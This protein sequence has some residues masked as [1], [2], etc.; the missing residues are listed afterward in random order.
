M[1]ECPLT[2]AQLV[3]L[4]AAEE[5]N[6][7][8]AA[9]RAYISQQCASNHIKNLEAQYGIALFNRKPSLTLT[10]A[11]EYLQQSLRQI[12]LIEQNTNS[13]I[14]EINKGAVGK[15]SVG[16]NPTRSRILMPRVLEKFSTD[17]PK[18]GVSLQCGDTI[19]NLHLLQKGKLDLVIGIGAQASDVAPF[20]VTPLS[21]EQIF[22]LTTEAMIQRYC[23]DF[24][25]QLDPQGRVSLHTLTAFPFCRNLTGST[26]TRLID[27][28]LYQEKIELNTRYNI[29]DYDT[30][31]ELCLSDIAAV[32]CPAM[33]LSR[34][35]GQTASRTYRTSPLV[36][37]IHEVRDEL[38]IDL[39]QNT[40]TFQSSFVKNFVRILK[41]EVQTYSGLDNLH[42]LIK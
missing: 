37:P 14:E 2:T 26:L 28:Y 22:F 20:A 31:M 15:L 12:Q 34:I 42:L 21:T 3:F 32:F 29:S 33:I 18:V 30:Q 5:L 9:R 16:I 38:C 27:T 39:V 35:F 24:Y 7:A 17:F 1:G 40:Y 36:F 11:G 6:I 8:R 13:G 23:P 4:Y 19:S 41:D 25:H 10:P